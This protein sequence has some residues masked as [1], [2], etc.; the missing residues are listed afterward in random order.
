[1]LDHLRHWLDQ[2]G[3]DMTIKP[4]GLSDSTTPVILLTQNTL[5]GQG[6]HAVVAANG[7][8][9]HDPFHDPILSAT[10][11]YSHHIEI[12]KRPERSSTTSES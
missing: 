10:F 12:K 4:G 7:Q 1:M 6:G 9:I 11:P 5:P 3:Y 8:I 2:Q